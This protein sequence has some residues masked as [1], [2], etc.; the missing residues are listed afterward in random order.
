MGLS[1]PSIP[2]N[3]TLTFEVELISWTKDKKY[4][5][6]GV[7][8]VTIG[9]GEGWRKPEDDSICSVTMIGRIG[10][11]NGEIF[12]NTQ[13]NVI[14]IDI[15]SPESPV[16]VETMLL[17]MKKGQRAQFWI[18]KDEMYQGKEF[19]GIGPYYLKTVPANTEIVFFEVHM[20]NFEFPKELWELT[21]DDKLQLSNKRKA[22]G[23]IF[24]KQGQYSRSKKRYENALKLW[25]H[26][27]DLNDLQKTEVNKLKIACLS[28]IAFVLIK[29]KQWNMVLEKTTEVLQLDKNNC[30]A[31]FRRGQA[32]AYMGGHNEEALKDLELAKSNISQVGEE[33]S[34]ILK[35]I[36]SLEA[37]LRA[38]LSKERQKEKDIFKN[39]FNKVSLVDDEEERIAQEKIRAKEKQK[40]KDNF[41]NTDSDDDDEKSEKKQA[42]ALSDNANKWEQSRKQSAKVDWEKV[43]EAAM[44]AREKAG[45]LSI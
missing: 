45:Y 37:P 18:E 17:S 34:S 14:D 26:E 28:N 33:S 44:K 31:L 7:Q 20:V 41:E 38:R 27:K 10:S 13:N 6:D 43:D 4:I 30:K 23:N 16:G 24:F 12:L 39:V 40:R 11:E 32:Y 5:G 3:S 1:P 22:I 19:K 42:D 15:S 8:K 36:S 9:K 21:V 25:Q 29:E 2:P 35:Q